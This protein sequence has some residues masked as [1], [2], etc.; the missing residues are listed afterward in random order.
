MEQ[1][2]LIEALT[3]ENTQLKNKL[4]LNFM[5]AS[6]EEKKYAEQLFKEQQDEI[7]VLSVELQS[8]RKSRDAFQLENAQLKRKI[9][10]L[11]KKLKG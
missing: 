9:L 7:A 8:I 3:Q 10:S 4:A 11:E 5:D 6:E 1:E 2:F